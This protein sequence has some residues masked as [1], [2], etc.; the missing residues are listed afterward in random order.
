MAIHPH[1]P[2]FR[3]ERSHDGP[4]TILTPAGEL[5]LATVDVLRSA[6]LRAE[7]EGAEEIVLDLGRLE[8]VAVTGVRA[9]LEFHRRLP[10]RLTLRRGVPKVQRTFQLTGVEDV[11]QWEPRCVVMQF[12]TVAERNLKFIRRL[13]R[14]YEREGVE[15]FVALVPPEVR[16]QPSGTASRF[17]SVGENVLVRSDFALADGAVKPLWS[18]HEF[19]QGFL[20]RAASFEHEADALAVSV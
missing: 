6:L 7:L 10:D 14:V 3:V 4:A 5:D 1:G 16:W 8:F 17:T 11:L 9:I 2:L 15:A 13:W 18:L 20:V 19:S 12:P